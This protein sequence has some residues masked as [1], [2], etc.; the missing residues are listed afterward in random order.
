M[1]GSVYGGGALGKT[2]TEVGNDG[3]YPTATVNLLGGIIDGDAYGGG[4]G[5]ASTA[6]DAG[7]TVV[8]LNGLHAGTDVDE[9]TLSSLTGEGKPL[10]ANGSGYRVKSTTKGIVVGRIFGSNN[11]NGTPKGNV[12]VH[13]HSTQNGEATQ[14]ANTETLT[15]AKVRERYDVDAV[16]G[17]GNLAAYNPVKSANNNSDEVKAQA[18][19]EV[20]I[21]GCNLTSIKQVYGGGNAASVPATHVV[22]NGTYEI[23]EVFGGGNG[24]DKISKNGTLITN[25]GANV[26]FKDYWDYAKEE[27]LEDY[28]T[29]DKRLTN[30]T[31]LENYVYGSGKASVDIYGGLVHR[32]FG[33][34]DDASGYGR[35]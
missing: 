11:L 26:G 34:C 3:V 4:L 20:I 13:V 30:T 16:Y 32:V 24:L 5:D 12:L 8:N 19:A 6:A 23:E 28:N 21:D 25:P 15:N 31:F 1:H 2:N 7:N 18:F 17:G 27:D 35:V 14:I 22:V 33:G 29:K 10:E 9:T